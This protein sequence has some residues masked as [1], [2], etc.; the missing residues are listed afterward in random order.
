MPDALLPS[1]AGWGDGEGKLAERKWRGELR[2]SAHIYSGGTENVF[3]ALAQVEEAVCHGEACS[4]R[5]PQTC[6]LGEEPGALR[7]GEDI[8]AGL[9]GLAIRNL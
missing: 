3:V 4:M 8:S 2:L 7:D 1:P 6:S 9:E 5:G